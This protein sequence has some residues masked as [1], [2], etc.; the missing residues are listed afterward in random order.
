MRALL[1]LVKTNFR[2]TNP[3]KE[4]ETKSAFSASMHTFLS[5]S[6]PFPPSSKL[7]IMLTLSREAGRNSVI[8]QLGLKV[9]ELTRLTPATVVG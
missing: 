4:A 3:C 2:Q 7:V 9:R 6:T 5:A 1:S 8:R